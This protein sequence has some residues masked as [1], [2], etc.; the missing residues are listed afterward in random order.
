[1]RHFGAWFLAVTTVL[2]LFFWLNPRSPVL[3][4]SNPLGSRIAASPSP[5]VSRSF[6]AAPLTTTV[7]FAVIGDYG[8]GTADET[9]VA[10]LVKSWNPDFIITVGDNNY[11][12]GAAST[13]D[14][15]I[16]RDYHEF[17]VPYQ[18]SYAHSY[19]PLIGTVI[20]PTNRFFPVL[21][22]HDWLTTG[23]KPYFDYFT[24][25]GNER[26]YDFV[27]GPVHLFALNSDY[28]EPDGISSSSIQAA[29]LKN[30]LAASSACW[31]L[32][33]LH[34]APF[35]SGFHG[36]TA[37][38]QWPYPAWGADAV[39]AGHDHTYERIV[40]NGIPYFVNGLGG[41]S[42]YP[43]ASTPVTGSQVRYNSRF[44]AMLIT[45]NQETITYEFFAVGGALVDTHT[46]TGGCS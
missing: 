40:R 38:F 21:G 19:L 32:V 28:H 43:F 25:P 23:A 3:A 5:A 7:R 29:W 36:S 34:V 24:L 37:T 27:L 20:T 42:R 6:Q 31:N 11:P 45:A 2:L 41:H 1:M 30:R 13:I 46:Q 8:S 17:I 18:G 22:N 4:Q 26:Y 10:N 39:L 15:N 9:A 12:N 14:T 16:G 35:S 44:G 33:Y